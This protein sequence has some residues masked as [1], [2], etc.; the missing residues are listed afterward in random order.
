MLTMTDVHKRYGATVA[1]A[2][3]SLRVS[4]GSIHGL[5]GQN[6]AGK[7]TLLKIL[8]GAESPDDGTIELAGE[9]VRLSSPADAH[10]YGIGIVYQDFSLLPNLTVAE[11]IALGR[12]VT[13]RWAIDTDADD[14]LA[15]QSLDALMVHDIPVDVLVAAAHASATSARRDR[16]GADAAGI[17]GAR[18]RRTDS[19]AQRR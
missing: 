6:G 12:E 13:K 1:L 18:V 3:A 4:A 7:S 11:N 19:G 15:R 16:Q 17:A 10:R 8:A 14:E 2:G 9:H 5:I